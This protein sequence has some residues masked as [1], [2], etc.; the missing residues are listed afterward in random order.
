MERDEFYKRLTSLLRELKPELEAP[1]P[2]PDTHLW[3]V[4]YVDS[5]AMLEIIFFVEDLVGHEIS[6]DDDFLP[7]FYTMEAIFDAYVTP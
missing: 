5:L 6:L 2:L 1:D 7:N 3:V 4:G